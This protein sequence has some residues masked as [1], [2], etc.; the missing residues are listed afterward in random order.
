MWACA[1][2][3]Q[4]FLEEEEEEED[5][6]NKDKEEEEDKDN[7]DKENYVALFLEIQKISN[8]F[9]GSGTPPFQIWERS[10]P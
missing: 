5:D 7:K 10:R 9:F 2:D 8:N 3:F 6:D 4:N 1:L